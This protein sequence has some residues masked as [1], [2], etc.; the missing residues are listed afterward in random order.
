M[1]VLLSVMFSFSVCLRESLCGGKKN[2]DGMRLF[3][4]RISLYPEIV[5]RKMS[6]KI[7]YCNKNFFAT[8]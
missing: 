3:A 4:S 1:A 6:V 7:F 5:K 8:I 2:P